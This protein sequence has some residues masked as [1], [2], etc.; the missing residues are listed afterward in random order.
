[1]SF[2]DLPHIPMDN[3]GGMVVLFLGIVSLAVFV[4][5]RWAFALLP[6][7]QW[8][9]MAVLLRNRTD[10]YRWNGLNLT[11]YGGITASAV[12]L[13]AGNMLFLLGA[14]HVPPGISLLFVLSL[15]SLAVPASKVIAKVVE[16]KPFT[17]TIGGASFTGL[18][19]APVTAV[20]INGMHH[21]PDVLPIL[22]ALSALVISFALGEGIGRL[23]CISYG[24]CYGKPLSACSPVMQALFKNLHFRFTGATKKIAY[25]G[26]LE[27]VPVVPIQAVT[28]VISTTGYLIGMALFLTGHF[29]AG[30]FVA[31]LI[32]QVW[33]AVSEIWRADHRGQ[34]SI[35]MYQVMSIVGMGYLIAVTMVVPSSSLAAPDLLTGLLS[36]W[37]P[38]VLLFLQSVWIGMFL[39]MGRSH[40]TGSV[41]SLFVNKEYLR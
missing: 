11:Y 6:L 28:A 13:A 34:G 26:N 18:V 41:L 9:I 15:M 17:F 24:C 30:L 16:K 31:L 27:S 2:S 10:S 20:A 33:R 37:T 40:M 38:A 22:P 4:L 32:T 14:I 39:F 25:A 21:Q 7:E 23:A 5:F 1:M 8:Q 29:A 35:S 3:H 19:M 36:L 12:T